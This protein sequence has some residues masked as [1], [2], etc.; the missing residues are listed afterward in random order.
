MQNLTAGTPNRRGSISHHWAQA[1][2]IWAVTARVLR[3]T[4]LHERGYS[5]TNV[6]LAWGIAELE[7][8]EASEQKQDQGDDY[9]IDR[10][11]TEETAELHPWFSFQQL[12]GW[13]CGAVS[14][15]ITPALHGLFALHPS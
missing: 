3:S 2:P 9:G 11:G 14:E 4:V 7:L 12:S 6:H 13:E 15:A 1:G 8:E 5:T 10:G